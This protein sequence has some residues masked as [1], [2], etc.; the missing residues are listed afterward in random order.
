[1]LLCVEILGIGLDPLLHPGCQKSKKKSPIM[2]LALI[3]DY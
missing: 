1:M 2:P 3:G